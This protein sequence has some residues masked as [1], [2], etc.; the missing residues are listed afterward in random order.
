MHI[1]NNQHSWLFCGQSGEAVR[2]CFEQTAFLLFWLKRGE[3]GR[4]SRIGQRRNQV[5]DELSK[6]ASERFQ[7]SG[8]LSS[9]LTGKMRSQQIEERSVRAGYIP[10]EAISMKESEA[11]CKSIRFTLGGL[12]RFANHCLPTHQGNLSL[13]SPRLVNECMKCTQV[14]FSANQDWANDWLIGG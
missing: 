12:A 8:D 13:T 5:R 10:R 4:K 3:W 7:L 6:L 14:G 11:L 2:Q 1:L 9:G